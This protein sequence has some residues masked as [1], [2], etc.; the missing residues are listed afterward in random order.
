MVMSVVFFLFS[1][2]KLLI[3]ILPKMASEMETGERI[4]EGRP[5]T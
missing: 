3:E 1:F 5:R 4:T 2:G